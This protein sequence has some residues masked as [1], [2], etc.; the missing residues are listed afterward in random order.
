MRSQGTA[1]RVWLSRLLFVFFVLLLFAGFQFNFF[2]VSHPGWFTGL[3][4]DSESLVIGRLLPKSED[5]P[6]ISSLVLGRV[7]Y[8]ENNVAET[9]E[10]YFQDTS[11]VS[12]DMFKLYTGQFGLQ[13]DIYAFVDSAMRALYV[14]AQD[15]LFVLH[16]L[17]SL[18]LA[19]V[20]ALLLVLFY[21]EYGLFASVAG[22]LII[23]FSPWMT[24][25]ARN[26]Y[27][28]PFTW[29][30]PLVLA[31]WFYVFRRPVTGRRLLLVQLA[32]FVALVL[33]MLCGFEYI[34]N[35]AGGMLVVVVFGLLKYGANL[36]K[37]II[38]TAIPALTSIAALVTALFLHLSLYALMYG[39]YGNA[40]RG[41]LGRVAYRS[42]GGDG[43]YS[44]ELQRSLDAS[45]LDVF[46]LYWRGITNGTRILAA[47]SV[48]E[49]NAESI[50]IPALAIVA[51]SG[52]VFAFVGKNRS[53]QDRREHY[54]H[55]ALLVMAFV[56]SIS[57]LVVG[58]GHSYIHTHMNYVLWHLPFLLILVPVSVHL[59]EEALPGQWKYGAALI[60][61]GA[62][63]AIGPHVR[64][65]DNVAL[66]TPVAVFQTDR[67][68]VIVQEAGI[69]FDLSCDDLV[70]NE[71]FF[72]HVGGMKQF[73]PE[74][75]RE[76]GFLNLDFNWES[77]AIDIWPIRAMTGRCRTYAPSPFIDL[78]KL[79]ITYI[80][81]GQYRHLGDM[82]RIWQQNITLETLTDDASD[83]MS[84]AKVTDFQWDRGVH[85]TKTGFFVANSFENRQALIKY[86]G[87]VVSGEQRP[88]ETIDLSER[89]ITFFFAPRSGFT[90]EPGVALPLYPIA[91]Q[92]AQ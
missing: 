9:F 64:S 26:L 27:W 75:V 35:I 2:K 57:W 4:I 76:N 55:I 38:Q 73:L 54:S 56:A 29:F 80:Q 83:S 48:F 45:V 34:T 28:V 3:Q 68:S 78:D 17:T 85:L 72:L 33:R 47:E 6:P 63:V 66:K 15:R 60:V 90:I 77:S 49:L 7:N 82:A 39:S 65:K 24:N 59:V 25:F 52:V 18:A 58:K 8:A 51:I 10:R 84:P 16:A 53:G 74:P 87:V 31:W 44:D 40:L 69:L 88:F 19:S 22:A 1:Q 41:F 91:K 92:A 36:K 61:G 23:V 62:I 12:S 30:V 46:E 42:H 5:F 21:R 86:D 13:G 43:D 81:F 11:P 70:G 50:V 32:F 79:P 20:L 71:R 14:G 37:L 67:A 89:W